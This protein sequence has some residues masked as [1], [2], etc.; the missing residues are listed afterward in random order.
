M[1]PA[2][3]PHRARCLWPL[4]LIIV[5]CAGSATT[6]AP[7]T[8]SHPQ[9]TKR[10]AAARPKN[11]ERPQ[12]DLS[13]ADRDRYLEKMNDLCAD[14]FCEGPFLYHFTDLNCSFADSTCVLAFDMVTDDPTRP[15]L[16]PAR[17]VSA[18]AESTE[19]AQLLEVVPPSDCVR[20]E[21]GLDSDGPPCT[22]IR[23]ACVLT[24]ISHA[25]DFVRSNWEQLC[26]CVEAVENTALPDPVASGAQA[27]KAP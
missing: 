8:A 26:K 9:Q 22:A 18:G 25:G 17:I 1:P 11:A 2:T 23:A 15:G 7:T 10:A 19:L 24:P 12:D 20:D 21:A 6:Q 4:L 5:S 13:S 27:Q 14:T 16:Q 3:R